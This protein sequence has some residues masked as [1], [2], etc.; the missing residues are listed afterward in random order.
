MGRDRAFRS[1]YFIDAIP[2]V[3]VED[4][5]VNG[6]GECD[7]PTPI[8]MVRSVFKNALFLV[9]ERRRVELN[10]RTHTTFGVHGLVG[11]PYSWVLTEISTMVLYKSDRNRRESKIVFQAIFILS[12]WRHVIAVVFAKWS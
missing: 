10:R 6:I 9:R 7:Q 1:Y 3:L 11:L 5:V 4:L 2:I 8:L 12:Y